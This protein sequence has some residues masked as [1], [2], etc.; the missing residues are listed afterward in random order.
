MEKSRESDIVS[1]REMLSEI[2]DAKDHIRE[3]YER[4]IFPIVSVS[5]KYESYL[6]KGLKKS[7]CWLGK[8]IIAGTIGREPY[9]VKEEKR[10]LVKVKVP[11]DRLEPRVTKGNKFNGVVVFRGP[12]D[13]EDLEIIGVK[14]E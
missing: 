12:I 14:S 9:L 6:K 1:H 11:P 8:N 10:I 5:P 4:G 7:S 3:M 13:P 2:E